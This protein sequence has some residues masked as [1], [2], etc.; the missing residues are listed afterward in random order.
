MLL[1][2]FAYVFVADRMRLSSFFFVGGSENTCILSRSRS[3]KVIDY[4]TNRKGVCDFLLVLHSN[5]SPI[6]PRFRYIGGFL[7]INWPSPRFHPK[8]GRSRWASSP[9][10]RQARARTLN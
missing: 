5:L 7:L 3:S 2:S 8:F 10:L 6:L 1:K 9:V 4:G